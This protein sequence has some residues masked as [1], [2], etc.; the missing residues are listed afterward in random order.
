[1]EC[2][3]S[4]SS[5]AIALVHALVKSHLEPLEAVPF[6]PSLQQ[7]EDSKS[8]SNAPKFETRVA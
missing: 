7:E 6:F 2:E 1:M 3:F 8:P 4:E 5:F